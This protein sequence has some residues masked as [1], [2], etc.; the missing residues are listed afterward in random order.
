MLLYKLKP[1]DRVEIE[2]ALLNIVKYQSF[3]DYANQWSEP[4]SRLDFQSRNDEGLIVELT[5]DNRNDI[6]GTHILTAI[7]R[8][9]VEYGENYGEQFCR[10]IRLVTENNEVFTLENKIYLD[11]M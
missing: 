5:L 6:D 7:L 1:D 2:I 10:A 4:L 11:R 3:K 9:I 8:Y